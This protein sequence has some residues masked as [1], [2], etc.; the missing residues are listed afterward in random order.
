MLTVALVLGE[1]T[2]ASLY[3]YQTFPVCIVFFYQTSEPISVA[4]SLLSLFLTWL[5]LLTIMMLG[6]RQARRTGCGRCL[7]FRWPARTDVQ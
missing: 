1:Y 6:G 2:M 3:L 4:A 5:F 7:V